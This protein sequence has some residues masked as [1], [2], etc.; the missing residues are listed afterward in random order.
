M[1]IKTPNNLNSSLFKYY[2]QTAHIRKPNAIYFNNSFIYTTDNELFKYLYEENA[3]YPYND[4]VRR[5]CNY[6]VYLRYK[7]SPNTNGLYTACTFISSDDK[8]KILELLNYT[9]DNYVNNNHEDNLKLEII[10]KTPRKI[11]LNQILNNKNDILQLKD[12]VNNI[13]TQT[14]TTLNL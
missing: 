5:F 4:N 12:D 11:E 7:L 13:L 14:S 6:S 1:S 3:K 9:L 10:L 8:N 2:R